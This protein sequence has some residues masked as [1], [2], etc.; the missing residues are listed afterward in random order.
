MVSL[1]PKE[2][3]NNSGDNSSLTIEN[4]AAKFSYFI[5]QFHLLHWQTSS[6]AEHQALSIYDGLLDYQDEIIEKMMGYLGRRPKSFKIDI[7]VDYSAGAPMR[8][9]QELCE[10]TKTLKSYAEMNNMLDIANLADSISGEAN[11]LKYLLTLS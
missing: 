6:I 3:L 9:A 1:F 5:E 4:V 2:M 7:I 11:K 8:I 10:F